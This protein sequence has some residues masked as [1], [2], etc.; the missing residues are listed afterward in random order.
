MRRFAATQLWVIVRGLTV[1]KRSIADVA[2][3]LDRSRRTL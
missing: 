2:F 1:L 3:L